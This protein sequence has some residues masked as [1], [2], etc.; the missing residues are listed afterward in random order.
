MTLLEAKQYLDSFVNYEA[1]LEQV[2]ASNFSLKRIESFLDVL[3][4]PQEGMK[5]VH[6]G[7]T[8]GKGSTCAFVASVLSTAGYKV[9]LYT[10]PHL[11]DFSERIRILDKD[12][13]G[14]KSSFPGAISDEALCDI[15]EEIRPKADEFLSK[16]E[17]L[18]FFEF[19]TALA[20]MY[21]KKEK[22]DI[23][24][25]EVG[26][27]GRLDATNAVESIVCGITSVSLDHTKQLGESLAAIAEEKAAIIKS[28]KQKVVIAPQ[29]EEV[30]SVLNNR[31]KEFGITPRIIK[32]GVSCFKEKKLKTNLLGEHQM[33]NAV[34]ALNIIESLG[35][36]GFF[37]TPEQIR[38][39]IEKTFWPGRCEIVRT[40]PVVMLDGAHN[41]ECSK[42]LV[43]TIK[44]VFPDKDVIIILGISKGKDVEAISKSLDKIKGD[45]IVVTQSGHLRA[46]NPD[47]VSWEDYFSNKEVAVEA[48]V[49]K[50]LL[51]AVDLATRENIILV[52]GS[53]FVVGEARKILEEKMILSG[54]KR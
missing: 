40:D 43:K 9:G 3:G 45:K 31:C 47:D 52:T 41:H 8:N 1:F 7:G 6:V 20:L 13:A 11:N 24:V 12:S 37:A 28:E 18:T 23:A 46:I 10:S 53:L 39:G 49:E 42:K 5:C 44:E 27:G 22:I 15:L 2:T 35:D 17:S 14:D 30:M 16:N 4:N 34:T 19:T 50:A 51:K 33:V 36:C 26:L 32:E 38:E 21:F 29:Q 25:L 48:S 54:G